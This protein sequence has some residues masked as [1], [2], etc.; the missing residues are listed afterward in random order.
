ME[1][2]QAPP[3]L[4]YST[5]ADVIERMHSPRKSCAPQRNRALIPGSLN[6]PTGRE[7]RASLFPVNYMPQLA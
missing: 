5:F 6:C 3:P 2:L 7:E 4:I 1:N